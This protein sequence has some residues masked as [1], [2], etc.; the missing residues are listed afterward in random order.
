MKHQSKIMKTTFLIISMLLTQSM[1]S[2]NLSKLYAEVS[3]AVVFIDIVSLDYSNVTANQN[4]DTEESLGSGV[5]IS[6]DGLIWTASHVVQT[7]EQIRVEFTDGDIYEAEVIA[8]NSIADVALIKI[9]DSFLLKEKK[10]ATIG[11]SDKVEIG[12]DIFLVGAP[13]GFKQSLSKGI[14]SGRYIPES[15]SNDFESVE[16]FQTDAAINPGNSGGPMFNMKGEVVGIASRIYTTTGGFD[17]IGFAV[18]SNIARDFLSKESNLWT[19][20]ESLLLSKEMARILNVPQES[21]L[22]I[23]QVSSKGAAAKIGLIG[24]FIPSIVGDREILL[25]GDII[26]EIAG[27]KF[28]DIDAPYK[29]K[30]KLKSIKKGEKV[31]IVI[32]R[33]GAIAKAE[34]EKQ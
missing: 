3:S 31:S 34:F 4:V 29:I 16:F 19:G 33:G 18:T 5:L 15:L 26:L 20:M 7:A 9:K 6:K 11:D 28:I 2:Q 30:E 32:L 13:H 10:V 27:V 24:G 21:G 1:I 12:Q 14:I 8:S 23:L 22:L 17:G 25:G